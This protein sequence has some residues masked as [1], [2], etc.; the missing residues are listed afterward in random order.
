M[1]S[2]STVI[3]I[4]V[5][6]LSSAQKTDLYQE[7]EI[8]LGKSKDE[9]TALIISLKASPRKGEHNGREKLTWQDFHESKESGSATQYKQSIKTY[10]FS[11]G[12][13]DSISFIVLKD[14][15]LQRVLN[16]RYSF[17]KKDS[18]AQKSMIK[19]VKHYRAPAYQ[20]NHIIAIGNGKSQNYISFFK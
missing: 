4:L 11:E 16:E 13:C 15:A 7:K 8:M 3:L 12:V 1:K 19:V 17:V 18:S 9:V 10:Y 20:V 14:E 2:Y 5:S 6:F